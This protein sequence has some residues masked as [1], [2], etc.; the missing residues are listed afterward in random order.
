V[1][2][3][4]AYGREV[5]AVD[6]GQVVFSGAQGGYGNT[7][8]IEHAGGIRTR[9]AHLSSMQV[10]AGQRVGAGTVIGRVGNTGRSTGAHLHFEVL[11][12]G[13]PVDPAAAATRFAS[14]LKVRGFDADLPLEQPSTSERP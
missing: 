6:G 12:D 9:Y 7:V 13:Q 1:D 5:P 11:Q 10:E 14:R 2:I 3:A 4:A 8:V